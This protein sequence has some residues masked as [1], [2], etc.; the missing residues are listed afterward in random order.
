[1]ICE[2]G[3]L[4]AASRFGK[5]GIS[6]PALSSQM[7]AL[8]Q[9]LGVS[10]FQRRPFLL[11]EQGKQFQEEAMRLRTRMNLLRNGLST[12][13]V[14]PLRIA[15]SDIIIRD[16]LPELLLKLDVVTRTRLIL[17]EAPSQDLACSV[18]DDEADL[19]IGMLSRHVA[20]GS[21]PL[22]EIMAS[23]P[24]LMLVPPSYQ[25]KVRE[26]NDVEKLLKG[27][28]KPRLVGL[29][30]NNLIMEHTQA[31]LRKAG[32]EWHP[33]IEVS[34]MS[35]IAKY[36]ALDFGFGFAM[37]S[38]PSR[39]RNEPNHSIEI[40]TESVPMLKLGVWH[41]EHLD[42]LAMQMLNLIRSFAKK[43]IPS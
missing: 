36:V 17:R 32:I 7:T 39:H 19:A 15:A 3:G 16:Y 35:H 33:T 14:K 29:P 42:P 20:A 18:R 22:V 26:W 30:Q 4:S 13:S 9:Y 25:E 41:T 23:L 5:I 31:A 21:T 24:L 12:E 28:E 40:P 8:E 38:P 27:K 2:S 37:K 6:Q 43:Y 34:S 1:M 10:L 11:T